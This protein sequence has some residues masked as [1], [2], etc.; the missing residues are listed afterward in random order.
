[1]R[2]NCFLIIAICFPFF[3]VGQNVVPSFTIPDTVCVNT[4]VNI[5]NT[6]TGASTYYWNFC[7]ADLNTA[8]QGTSIGNSGGLL[9]APVFIDYAF[10]N[11]NYYGFLTNY[12][13]GNLIRLD[14]GNSLLNTPT[15]VNLGNFGGIIPSGAGTEGIQIVYN[16]GNWY[17][18]IVGGWPTTGSTPR[19]LKIDFGPNLTNTTP[20]ATNWGNL[21]NMLQPIDLHV[22][23]ENNNWYGLTVNAENNTITRFSFTSSFNN[24]P[25][26]VNLGNIGNLAYPTGVYAINDNGFWRVFVV[27]GG[28]NTRSSGTYS[29][30]RLDFGSSLLNTPTGVNLGNPGNMLQHPRDFT[31]M[32]MCNQ[33][34]GFAVNGHFN[35]SNL[36]KL[37][38]N[39]NLSSNPTTTSL[40]NFGTLSFPHSISKLFRVGNDVYSFITNVD[41]NTIM[42]IKF[43]GCTNSSIPNSSLQNPPPVIYNSP[44]IYNINLTVDDGL[45]TQSTICKQVVVLAAPVHSP[46]QNLSVCPGGTIEIGSSIKPASYQWSTGATTDSIFVNAEGTYWVESDRYGCSVK[47]S[48][49]VTYSHLNLDFGFQQDMCSPKTVQFTGILPGVQSYLWNFGDGQTNSSSLNP[50]VSYTDYGSYNIKLNVKYNGSCV[51]SLTKSIILENIYDNAMVFNNDT[52]ICLGDSVLLKTINSISNYCWKTSAGVAPTLLSAYVKPVIPTTYVLTSQIA[53]PN[54]VTNPDFSSGNVG[55]TSDY[56]Y[57]SP[58]VTEGQYWVGASSVTWNQYMSDCHD[59]SSGNGNMLMVNGSPTSGM[60]AWSQTISVTPN[61]NYNFSVWISALHIDNPAKLHFAINNVELGN[62]INAGSTT[63]QWKQFFSTWNSG[64]STSAIISIVN[65]NTIVAGNDFALDDIF[66]GQ[67]TTKTD[68]V[69]INVV[70]LCDSVKIN[71]ANKVCSPSDTL[72]YSIYKSPNCT[73]L[74]SMQVDH[75]F[76]NIVS[77]TA[78]SIKLL[79]KKNGTTTIKVAY[80]NNCKIVA[81]SLKV[82]IKFSPTS[83][84]FGPDVITCR[85]TSLLLNAGDG[86]VSYAWQNGSTDSTLLMN[87]PGTYNIVAQNLCGNQ[88]KDTIRLIRTPVISFTV[89][90]LAATVCMGDSVQFRAN[91][92]TSY[93][94]LPSGNFSQPA[95]ASTKA[96]VDATQNFTVFIS[97]SICKRDTTF[98]IPVIAS[99]GANITVSKSNDVNCGND[100]AILV[101]NGGVSYTWS[102]NLYISRNNGNEIT[103]KPYQNTTYVV[104]GKDQLGCFGQDSVTV[105]FF[106]TGNQKLFMPTAF[107]P[108]SDGKNDVFRPTFIGP[109]AKYDFS[110]YNRWGQLVYR[111]KVPGVGW[112][113]TVNGIPQKP[114]IYVFYIT[115]EGGCNGK[116]EQKGTFALIR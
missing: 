10:Y 85:D 49:I 8:P 20:V 87:A 55:F 53:G 62:D 59:H 38:F 83:I 39:N 107:T 60:K 102:P 6:T 64:N 36:I 61:T 57:A 28:D 97:D 82:A 51:D 67:A 65:N 30:T 18:I 4:P 33:I 115:A 32:K 77:Q 109:S 17:A 16:E 108:N 68:S 22:F 56:N 47:D 50:I 99:P 21:G 103:V 73:Q 89:S 76:A 11:G 104:R 35:N 100:S 26:A 41:N 86:F 48:F 46:T 110:I 72:A 93:A 96:M 27:N 40:G 5:T 114:D 75:A 29:L 69:N 80:A 71:G 111:S 81:D 12:N 113:G 90:P 44:G 92:G 98:I 88:L 37:D 7:V 23:K 84:N 9:S 91:G 66:F 15:A 45:P 25:T 105:Y 94:W 106:K 58:N 43:N 34:V 112:D 42:R 54:L 31:I 1:M 3:C 95:A 24:T 63:C 19:I 79:F 78:T 14:F 74:Y 13:P 116:F 52:S 70:G 2:T 101:A